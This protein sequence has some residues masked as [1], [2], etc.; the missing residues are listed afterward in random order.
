MVALRP[1]RR[2][3]AELGRVGQCFQPVRYAGFPTGEWR[4]GQKVG[5]TRRTGRITVPQKG[6][7]RE[8][9]QNS[10][11]RVH[12]GRGFPSR[13]CWRKPGRIE[14]LQE[15]VSV[16]RRNVLVARRAQRHPGRACSPKSQFGLN[17]SSW[18]SASR[19]FVTPDFQPAR[20]A[21]TGKLALPVAPV[22]QP[23][24]SSRLANW[25]YGQ[26]GCLSHTGGAPACDG[27]L[28]IGAAN[29]GL[30]L[31]QAISEHQP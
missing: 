1:S 22:F 14:R 26:A 6:A 16:S 23:R 30:R 17:P 24:E 5:V 2:A 13:I 12:P 7:C 18:D 20:P 8:Y 21:P 28:G 27:G 3:A 25:R 15:C 4:A 10:K 31:Q 9:A 29:S 19:L 11:E